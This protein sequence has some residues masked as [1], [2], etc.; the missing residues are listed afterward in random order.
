MF[1]LLFIAMIRS[2]PNFF[3]AQANN[4]ENIESAALDLETKATVTDAFSGE[5]LVHFSRTVLRSKKNTI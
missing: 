3:F 5:R 2:T 1:E 4:V